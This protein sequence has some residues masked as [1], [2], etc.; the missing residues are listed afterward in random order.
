MLNVVC[1]AA[2]QLASVD[3][4]RS[5]ADVAQSTKVHTLPLN[6]GDARALRVSSI[7]LPPLQHQ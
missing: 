5:P 3:L 7:F 2:A 6:G 1:D 4:W